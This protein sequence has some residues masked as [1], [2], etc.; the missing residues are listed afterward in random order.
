MLLTLKTRLKKF[1]FMTLS[2]SSARR[3]RFAISVA[4]HYFEAFLPKLICLDF[5]ILVRSSANFGPIL[6]LKVSVDS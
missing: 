4:R 3:D 1:I 5:Y 2:D 6:D